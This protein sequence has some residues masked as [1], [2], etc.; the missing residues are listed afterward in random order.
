MRVKISRPRREGGRVQSS[1]P[2]VSFGPDAEL[3]LALAGLGNLVERIDRPRQ[4][5]R[6]VAVADRA[7]FVD[8][9]AP[10]EDILN[11][12]QQQI[13][14][15]R[16]QRFEQRVAHRDGVRAVREIYARRDP[17]NHWQLTDLGAFV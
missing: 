8:A 10:A 17:L 1:T 3:L 2:S 7:R 12:R 15:R 13:R 5:E 11:W 4:P 14:R 16:E 6:P 9:I